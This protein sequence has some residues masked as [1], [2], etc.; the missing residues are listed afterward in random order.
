MTLLLN[1]HPEL[2]ATMYRVNLIRFI[3][4]RYDPISDKRKL[5]L[6]LSDTNERLLERYNIKF[7][8]TKY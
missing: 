4:K 3:F 5:E 2:S 8:K 1:S 7:D 6:A